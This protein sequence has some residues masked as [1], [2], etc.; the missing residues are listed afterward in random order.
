VEPVIRP[1]LLLACLLVLAASASALA[2]GDR[3]VLGRSIG[4]IAIGDERAT[5]AARRGD[6]DGIVIARTPKPDPVLRR[7]RAL[8]TVLVSYPEL[9]LVARFST[10]EASTQA[11]RITTRSR[12]YRT[13]KGAG[14]G[15]RRAE[16]RR[17]HPAAVC[18]ATICRIGPRIPGRVITRFILADDVVTRVQIVELAPRR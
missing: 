4:A 1:A 14:V 5:I 8:D 18:S 17:R 13:A 2:A 7:I 10:D 15:S 16:L 3:I 12:R 6:E 11:N 9:A